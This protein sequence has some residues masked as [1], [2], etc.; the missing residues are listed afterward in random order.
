MKKK[1]LIVM[2]ALIVAIAS[3]F[4]LTAC[5]ETNG[6]GGS[7][8][9]N[10]CNGGSNTGNNGNGGSTTGNTGNGDNTDITTTFGSLLRNRPRTKIFVKKFFSSTCS[11][12]NKKTTRLCEWIFICGGAKGIR[13]PDL[14]N[15]IQTRYQLRHN[16]TSDYRHRITYFSDLCKH[17]RT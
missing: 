12:T 11:T 17:F 3:A 15:A 8:T 13:T 4:T 7:N 6:N 2:F 9:G 16:P 10:T 5:G 1:L 14:L